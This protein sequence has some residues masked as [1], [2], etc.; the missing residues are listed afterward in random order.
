VVAKL[1]APPA[2]LPADPPE[3]QWGRREPLIRV[4]HEHPAR[5]GMAARTFGPLG[6]FDPHVRDR[7]RRPR[8]DPEGRGVLY[9]ARDLPTA[10]AEAYSGQWPTVS[11]CPH[12]RA[13]WV[14][15]G[16]PI[17]LL[18]LTSEGAL[19]LGAVGTLAWGDEPRALTQRWGR[20]IYEQYTRLDGIW[21][22]SAHQGGELVALWDRA[23]ALEPAPG[24]DRRL[25]A[26][27]PYVQV[28]LAGQR[29]RPVRTA[30]AVCG[31][32]RQYGCTA[33]S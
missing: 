32:C 16:E 23:P 28:A 12:A 6:R 25:W 33:R 26:V 29:R 2:T 3:R 27:W 18:D 30:A 15:P 8:E 10:L 5:D 7:H 21:Y 31:T 1:G 20:R 9:L 13:G 24:G 4:Y 19:A 14:R 22:R 11:I 17:D